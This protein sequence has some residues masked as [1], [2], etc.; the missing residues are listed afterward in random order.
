MQVRHQ[1]N[2]A[3]TW[4]SLTSICNFCIN[5]EAHLQTVCIRCSLCFSECLGTRLEYTNTKER[6]TLSGVE[7][8]ICYNNI[9]DIHVAK[10]NEQI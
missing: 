10:V 9:I 4:T 3:H 1:L 7:R 8:K 5:N 6:Q 2:L